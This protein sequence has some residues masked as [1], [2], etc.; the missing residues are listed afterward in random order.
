MENLDK[1]LF[2]LL[3][4]VL[5]YLIIFLCP[6]KNKIYLNRIQIWMIFF[7]KFEFNLIF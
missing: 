2:F 3:N 6:I 1:F 4:I 7:Y 5:T